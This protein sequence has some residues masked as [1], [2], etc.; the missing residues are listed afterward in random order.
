MSSD[1]TFVLKSFD[2]LTAL[3]LHDALALR[4]AVFVVEQVCAYQ[5]PDGLDLLAR[6]LF[7]R[8]DGVLVGYARILPPK[9]RFDVTSIGRVVVAATE[10]KSGLGRR[11]MQEAIAA[12]ER[13][14][15]EPIALSAQAHLERFYASLGFVPG[16]R[17]DE[18]GIP[19]VAMRRP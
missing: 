8:L 17:Y 4:A 10:R 5:D 2:E 9:S 6:H 7:A 12:I 18:D 16:E 13:S 15:P 1:P 3:E 19:Q 14:G 11:L